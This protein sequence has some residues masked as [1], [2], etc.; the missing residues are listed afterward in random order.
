MGCGRRQRHSPHLD[1]CASSSSTANPPPPVVDAPATCATDSSRTHAALPWQFALSAQETVLWHACAAAASM[2]SHPAPPTRP[3][4]RPPGQIPIPLPTEIDPS[5]NVREVWSCRELAQA[6]NDTAVDLVLLKQDGRFNCTEADWPGQASG[7]AGTFPAAGP[8]GPRTP[9]R[10]LARLAARGRGCDA[11]L[12]WLQRTANAPGTADHRCA[13][14]HPPCSRTPRRRRP[15]PHPP[16]HTHS[17]CSHPPTT[18]K[19]NDAGA[20]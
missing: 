20:G 7:R 19:P 15:P 18:P 17:T 6:T 11:R 4:T 13:H 3:A 10:C 16:K 12:P 14:A 9:R 1:G 5:W 2:L 8:A